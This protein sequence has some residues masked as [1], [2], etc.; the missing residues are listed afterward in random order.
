MPDLSADALDLDVVDAESHVLVNRS[1]ETLP[2]SD[3]ESTIVLPFPNSEKKALSLSSNSSIPVPPMIS[4]VT[5]H[6][7]IAP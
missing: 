4:F 5:D 3:V 1:D 7:I 2:F 6:F